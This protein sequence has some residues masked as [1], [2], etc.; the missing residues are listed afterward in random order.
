MEARRGPSSPPQP[1]L[2]KP[3]SAARSSKRRSFPQDG[4]FC[5]CPPPPGLHALLALLSNASVSDYAGLNLPFKKLEEKD[6]PACPRPEC[7]MTNRG[8]LLDLSRG[9]QRL[10]TPW[11]SLP[12]GYKLDFPGINANDNV[13]IAEGSISPTPPHPK[14][15]DTLSHDGSEAVL[16]HVSLFFELTKRSNGL[17]SLRK[18]PKRCHFLVLEVL[19][20]KQ[21]RGELLPEWSDEHAKACSA[22]FAGLW[23]S[24]YKGR[25]N[26]RIAAPA[27][28]RF[29]IPGDLVVLPEE[30]GKDGAPLVN[31]LL[32]RAVMP[33]ADRLEGLKKRKE[34][35]GSRSKVP[36]E[37]LLRSLIMGG[38]DVEDAVRALQNLKR[39]EDNLVTKRG[40]YA[41]RAQVRYALHVCEADEDRALFML[42]NHKELGRN[43]DFILERAG[44]QHGL[45]FPTRQ[46]VEAQLVATQN[47]EGN[48]MANLKRQW[49][50]EVEM[51]ADLLATAQVEDMLTREMSVA[52]EHT[53]PPTLAERE[54][55]EQLYHHEFHRDNTKTVHFLTQAGTVLKRAGELG[56]PSRKQVEALPLDLA[57]SPRPLARSRPTSG[58]GAAARARRRLQ[59]RHRLPQVLPEPARA[60]RQARPPV[61]R[62]LR[63][64]L[65]DVRVRR[66]ARD[67][68]AQA[69]LGAHQPEAAQA[70]EE[71]PTQGAP[72]G[73]VRRRRSAA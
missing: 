25:V 20:V 48:A 46:Q 30:D 65:E 62:R 7:G 39:N 51:M 43:A 4:S 2:V 63:A 66:G 34:V 71:G 47:E 53:Y 72:C 70:A 59:P 26:G 68:A 55:I 27:G 28:T 60:R 18:L 29:V 10:I 52:F 21:P 42:E 54:H 3:A 19:G 57:R 45:G 5:V 38:N 64:L 6:G 36:E 8:L 15:V 49:K 41:T 37:D 11:G 12:L 50:C 14:A 56:K 32:G 23:Q 40:G 16:E 69:Y 9:V 1:A 17:L 31:Q 24:K 67:A 61:A 73:Q 33:R 35:F 22:R 13:Q 58:G 44:I